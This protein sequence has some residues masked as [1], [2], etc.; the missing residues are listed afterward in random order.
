MSLFRVSPTIS[1]P[2][3][4]NAQLSNAVFML[5]ISA[6][7]MKI[8]SPSALCQE[9]FRSSAGATFQSTL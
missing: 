5:Q 2:P 9:A 4:L 8:V 3:R 1:S 6:R 7:R